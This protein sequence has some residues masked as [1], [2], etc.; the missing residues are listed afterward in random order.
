MQLK[1]SVRAS[2]ILGLTFSACCLADP[3]EFATK[4]KPTLQQNCSACHN[5]ANPK[6]RI[7]FLKAETAKD[8]ESKRGLWR[9]VAIQLRNRTM[10]PVDSKLA[11]PDR[12]HIADWIEERLRVTA[13]NGGEFAGAAP[14]R[15]LNRREYHNTVRDLLGVDFAVSDV[16]P[17]DESGGTG[18]DTNGETLFIPPVMLERY[19]EAAQKIVDRVVIVP[20]YVKVVMSAA[21]E[22]PRPGPKP[23]RTMNAAEELSTTIQV[24]ADG[25]YDLRVSIE[26]PPVNPVQMMLKLDGANAGTLNYGRDPAGGAT[27]RAQTVT[28]TRGSHTVSVVAGDAPVSF[29]SL[30]VE[31]KLSDI[32]AEKRAL[33]YRLFGTEPFESSLDARKSAENLM[34]NFLRKAYRRPVDK[35]DVSRFIV[36]YDQAEKRGDPYEERIKL[37]LKATLVSP[38]FLF[39]VEQLDSKP[40]IHPLD[41]YDLAS[42]LSYFLWSTMPD[43]ELLSLAAADKLNNP[44]VLHAQVDRLLDDPRSRTFANTFVGQWL[45]THDVGGRVVPL[46]TELQHY[47]TPDAAADLREEPVLLFQSILN[48]NRSLL[49]LLT[50]NYT[51]LTERLV[52]FYELEGKVKVNGTGFT[53][54]EWPDNRRAGVLGMASVLAMTS[55]YKAGSPVLRGAWVLDTLLGTP[56]PPPPPDV[57]PLEPVGKSAHGTMRA[58]LVKHRENPACATCHNLMDPIGFGLENF[59]WMG[60]W[61]DNDTN[62]QPVDASGVMPSGE[63]FNGPVEL[64]QILLARKQEFARHMAGKVFGFALGRSLQDG[65]QCTVQKMVDTLEKDGYKARTLIHDVVLS[66]AFRNTEGGVAMSA[67]PATAPPKKSRA[68]LLGEK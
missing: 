63:R 55:H 18:F 29:Y 46:L 33:H 11:E 66:T 8:I 39:R 32:P 10:P 38:R 1:S 56:V 35:T 21:M 42:R 68:P 40:G 34:S 67:V 26:R 3:A 62:G 19:L 31:Q 2:L 30:T 53:R 47:Y 54:V 24:F 59:D 58:Q 52:K 25:K 51:F 41:Q 5:P 12:L 6:N 13:C 20:P 7:D 48:E 44:K 65:D 45:G 60:R 57:P 16:F 17:A 9:D 14:A 61:R 49:E 23:G 37:M 28:L 43:A 15:R 36:L 27:A 22:P 4:I 50:A 64:R